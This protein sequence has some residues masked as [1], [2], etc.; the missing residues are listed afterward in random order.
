M[1]HVRAW[2]IFYLLSDW[3]HV[4]L[5]LAMSVCLCVSYAC[6][7]VCM[8][9][10]VCLYDCMSVCLTISDCMTD[11]RY[12]C[13]T[14]CLM[15]CLCVSDWLCIC[16]SV[17]LTDCLIICL[18]LWPSIYLSIYLYYTV[19]TTVNEWS[20]K[21]GVIVSV[22]SVLSKASGDDMWLIIRNCFPVAVVVQQL[23][24]FCVYVQIL[25]AMPRFT[26]LRSALLTARIK[27]LRRQI[28]PWKSQVRLNNV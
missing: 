23:V 8:Y 12:V 9:V 25:K 6:L 24:L 14:V 11:Y 2:Q 5:C 16:L 1:G 10:Y 4:R 18:S 22:L 28:N 27:T 17:C 15:D 20:M 7:S 3:L 26:T 21:L 13:L 19:Y